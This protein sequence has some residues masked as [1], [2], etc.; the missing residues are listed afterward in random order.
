MYESDADHFDFSKNFT[1][2][3]PVKIPFWKNTIRWANARK[4]RT[5]KQITIES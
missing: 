2:R 3:L 4:A 1:L 5:N